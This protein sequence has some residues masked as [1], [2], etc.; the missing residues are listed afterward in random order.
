MLYAMQL[1]RALDEADQEHR[2]YLRGDGS[3]PDR[4]AMTGAIEAL[5]HE[6]SYGPDARG[7][8]FDLEA[9]RSMIVQDRDGNGRLKAPKRVVGPG[10]ITRSNAQRHSD[11]LPS[12]E[13]VAE[14]GAIRNK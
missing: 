7:C 4:L 12:A 13:D 8:T 6:I 9:A 1:V 14:L 11:L 10:A 5:K 2:A 3:L